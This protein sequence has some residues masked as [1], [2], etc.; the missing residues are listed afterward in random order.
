M[1]TAREQSF[2]GKLRDL[3]AEANTAFAVGAI[4][5][6]IGLY[7]IAVLV[8]SIQLLFYIHVAS[9]ASWFAM[10]IIGPTLLGPTLTAIG[11]DA[12]EEV[13]TALTP[14]I[15]FFMF[16]IPTT[17]VLSGTTLAWEFG[18]IGTGD[19]WVNA[20]LVLGWGLWVFGLV[21]VSPT[22]LKVYWEAQ[23]DSPDTEFLDRLERRII[24]AG[25]L[26]VVGLLVIIGIM[27]SIWL[28]PR[29][30]DILPCYRARSGSNAWD[31]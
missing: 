21:V 17:T 28:A 23:S 26:D 3:A 27:T 1:A 5:V 24:G 14:K 4:V 6:P 2:P 8:D 16:G 10:G 22:H 31:T 29:S 7:V 13:T 20:A 9:G 19:I 18:R 25:L 11:P 12:A 30:D 15:T